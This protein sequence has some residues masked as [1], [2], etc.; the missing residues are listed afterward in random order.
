MVIQYLRH[1]YVGYGTTTTR[2]ILDHLYVMYAKI[3]SAD[4][5]DNDARLRAPYDANLPIKALID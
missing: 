1:L 3:S 5:Q 2:S 4:L